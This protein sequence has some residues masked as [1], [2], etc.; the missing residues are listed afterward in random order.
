MNNRL[1][2]F[3]M[4]LPLGLA[5]AGCAHDTTAPAISSVT[6]GASPYGRGELGTLTYRATDLM[7]A[8]AP[9]V[10]PVTPL[11]V[12]SISDA[13]NLDRSSALG[14]IVSDLI[15]TR[16]VQDGHAVREIRLRS[17]VGFSRGEGEFL[18]SRNRRALMAPPNAAGIVTGTYAVGSDSLYVSLKLVSASDARIISA[19]DFVVPL[20][21]VWGMLQPDA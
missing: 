9:E 12:A 19:A 3:A 18:L 14:N 7:L 5:I 10:T 8:G 17:A 6:L 1:R 21:D 11:I 15:R 4:M 13:R 2:Q 16:L 20:G